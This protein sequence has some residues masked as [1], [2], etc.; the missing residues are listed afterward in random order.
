[1]VF[2]FFSIFLD[3]I[4]VLL[5]SHVFLYFFLIQFW[6]WR[7]NCCWNLV[8]KGLT[9]MK[10]V[11]TTKFQPLAAPDQRRYRL[12]PGQLM[13]ATTRWRRSRSWILWKLFLSEPFMVWWMLKGYFVWWMICLEAFCM[14]VSVLELT[15]K[16]S[17]LL[18]K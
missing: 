18:N 17:H 10:A 4:H 7:W 14:Q 5:I 13:T 6:F 15:L 9:R 1:M 16:F 12:Y 2:E 11:F 8:E 3:F